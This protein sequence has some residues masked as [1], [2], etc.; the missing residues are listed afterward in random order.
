LSNSK[1]PNFLPGQKHFSSFQRQLNMYGFVKLM[2]DNNKGAYYHEYFLRGRPVLSRLI[3]RKD[4]T[5]SGVRRKFDVESE[6]DFIQ[7]MPVAIA[8]G[9]SV[10]TWTLRH[11][12]VTT[13]PLLDSSPMLSSHNIFTHVAP[14]STFKSEDEQSTVSLDLSH[15]CGSLW[16]GSDNGDDA[17][18]HRDMWLE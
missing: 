6:P 5:E 3:F 11:R 14:L 12:D 13:V 16:D 4:Q 17:A 9:S 7:M 2:A 10:S 15:D 18:E 1:I 8:G